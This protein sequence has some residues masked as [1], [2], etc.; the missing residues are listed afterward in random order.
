MGAQVR[1]TEPYAKVIPRPTLAQWERDASY[2]KRMYEALFRQDFKDVRLRI[3]PN[4]R[5][6]LTLTSSRISQM[7]R[8]VGRAARTALLL[9]PLETTEISVTFTT[10][11]LPVATYEFS[12][13][14]KLNRY[15]NG[16]LTRSEPR[17]IRFHSL[18]C[19]VFLFRKGQ[20]RP[21]GRARRADP[22]QGSLRRRGQLHRVQEPGH[23]L[24]CVPGQ[25]HSEQ[26]PER[27]ER[28]QYSLGVLTTYD[29]E[30]AERLF[31]STGVNTILYENISQAL[32]VNNSTLP[33]VRSDFGEY[34]KGR[35]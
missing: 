30:L 31:L 23:R 18:R 20:S 17:R 2:R 32:G 34:A 8:A 28:V 13:L 27:A 29:R 21:D 10:G 16:L 11:G 22:G 24:Q 6:S 12:D 7:S 33:H 15:F 3:E 26:L 19:P 14:R 25:A 35:A 1:G 5:L 9:A 4:A